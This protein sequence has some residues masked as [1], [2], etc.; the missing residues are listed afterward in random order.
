MDSNIITI[1]STNR[2][3]DADLTKNK[4]KYINFIYEEFEK[5][6][7]E[8]AIP[9][10]IKIFNFSGTDLQVIIRSSNYISNIDNL[11]NHYINKEEYEKCS[12]LNKLKDRIVDTNK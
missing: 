4:E 8:S 11:L 1:P 12:K 5:L 6:L 7:K 2:D 3:L 9:E 10:H